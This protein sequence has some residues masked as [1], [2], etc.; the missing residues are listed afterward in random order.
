LVE[1]GFISISLKQINTQ[2]QE[3]RRKHDHKRLAAAVQG[4]G[5][6][7]LASAFWKV[8]CRGKRITTSAFITTIAPDTAETSF[9][10]ILAPCNKSYT[11]Y[12][13]QFFPT[14]QV[15]MIIPLSLVKKIRWKDLL[16]HYQC[17]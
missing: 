14:F 5:P 11:C 7:T 12:E 2:K 9:A 8:L 4:A 1:G 13:F 16:D 17:G 10:I 6:V 15:G 3:Q